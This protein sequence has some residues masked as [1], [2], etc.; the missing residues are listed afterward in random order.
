MPSTFVTKLL[1]PRRR[2]GTI[3]RS[4]LLE[5]L[6][7]VSVGGVVMLRAPAGYGKTTLLVDY[8]E[9][10]SGSIHWVTLDEWDRDPKTFLHYFRASIC[11][12]REK[13]E[14]AAFEA[15]LS[16]PNA[17]LAELTNRL[18]AAGEPAHVI[19]D[20]LHFLDGSDGVL[21]HI[22]HFIRRLPS[23][24]LVLLA[25]RTSPAIASIPR[26]RATNDLVEI[27]PA[28][29]FFSRDE[30]REYCANAGQKMSD[31]QLDHLLELTS[32]WPAAIALARESG[33]LQSESLA[34]R[35]L[36]EYLAAEVFERLSRQEQSFL[37]LTSVL[38]TLD[39]EACKRL[40]DSWT[41]DDIASAIARIE[42][43]GIP[44]TRLPSDQ[45]VVALHP[46]M[47]E[48]LV[49]R[50]ANDDE[51]RYRELN[52]V[53]ATLLAERGFTG[54]A[55]RHLA[56]AQDWERLSELIER[57][58]PRSYRS[59]RWQTVLAWLEF[60]PHEIR[61]LH[62]RMQMWEARLLSR[63]DRTDEALA[64]VEASFKA[65]PALDADA[66]A[67]LE[68]LR[69]AA[70][71]LKGAVGAA[72]EAARRAKS[73]AFT[74][75]ASVEIVSEAR[76]Q[77][78]V[79]L[80]VQGGFDEAIEELLA[81]LEIEMAR[82]DT[83][84]ASFAH[85]ALGSHY[86]AIGRLAESVHHLEQARHGWQQLGNKR[87]LSWVL[88]NLGVTYWQI[89]RDDAARQI[90]R[91]CVA[92]ARECGNT[93]A[94]G[95]ALTSLGDAMRLTGELHEAAIQY[96]EALR[97]ARSVGEKVL[98]AYSLAGLAEVRGRFGDFA[99]AEALA[100]EALASAEG[101]TANL[102]KALAIQVLGRLARMQ[103]DAP[104]AIERFLDAD[105]Y[106][107]TAG[108]A[109][110]QAETLVFLAEVLLSVRSN[111]SLA[112]AVLKRIPPIVNAL[113]SNACLLRHR[114]EALTI[115]RYAVS[116]RIEAGFYR[117]L[118]AAA[119]KDESPATEIA[120]GRYPTTR[121]TLL[122]AFEVS[123]GD[124]QLQG[125]EWE[126]ERSKELFVLLLLTQRPL[127]R[128]EIIGRLWPERGGSRSR[129]LF[130]TTLHRARKALYPE[131]FVEN[132]GSYSLQPAAGFWCDALLFKQFAQDAKKKGQ[133]ARSEV[134]QKAVELYSGPLTPGIKSEWMEEE[135]R[136]LEL[137]YSEMA[138]ALAEAYL[139]GG[140]HVEA[141]ELFER[142][143][144]IDPLDEDACLGAMRSHLGTG[145]T[146]GGIRAFRLHETAV[147]NELRES[148]SGALCE[149][150]S[151]L[152]REH[153]AK[154]PTA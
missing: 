18:A 119:S 5:R 74:G 88:N 85:G 68:S 52:R 143:M 111:R 90:Y 27:E 7:R 154:Q 123:V 22:D 141:A 6:E 139:R 103:G 95:F 79:A 116:R 121:V 48:F 31:E 50:L 57:E 35:H 78:A 81:V 89:G 97:I 117:R 44:V 107:A 41:V 137:V 125:V 30:T 110:E 126:G 105:R 62:P 20:D 75:N 14:L 146:K 134:I 55:A 132:G 24:A 33:V 136:L 17:V 80:G 49:A 113:G 149:L 64:V 99:T 9:Q 112:A 38:E 144:A 153:R 59:G 65:F 148:P 135:R 36:S 19:L 56:T 102:E 129:S 47:R 109:R 40:L 101:R 130:H 152:K 28:D 91:E 77:L 70:L 37:V 39:V 23:N 133:I 100:R 15:D 98:E 76:K 142:L 73:L 54:E 13:S 71:R 63:L 104:A 118:L 10:A 94:E 124:R 145:N 150:F 106:F 147:H 96:E 61:R 12:S 53:A 1:V 127:T 43:S 69:S 92:T 93:R 131:A 138:S 58:A 42:A 11:G 120:Q 84:A 114:D 45:P 8:C 86:G 32:G 4:R 60:M 21:A 25:S 108:A 122:G 87:E 66:A 82:G 16:E 34:H 3:R 26:L 151:R 140:R 51:E 46:L 115:S 29:L 83:A 2:E 67:E 72:V 128:D